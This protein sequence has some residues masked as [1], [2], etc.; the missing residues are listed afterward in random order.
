MQSTFSAALKKSKVSRLLSEH[1]KTFTVF[2]PDDE[3]FAKVFKDESL[4]CV[5]DFYNSRPC[6]ST[7]DLLSA[8]N[9]DTILLHFGKHSR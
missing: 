6:T 9:L 1:D 5:H 8:T 2:A 3:G 4:I 7:A